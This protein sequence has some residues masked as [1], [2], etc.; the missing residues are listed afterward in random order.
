[1]RKIL[2]LLAISLLLPVAAYADWCAHSKDLAAE[3]SLDGVDAIEVLAVSG[4]LEITGSS[5]TRRV[6][7]TGRACTGAEGRDRIDEIAIREERVGGTLRIIADVPFIE[8]EDWR[9][10][11]LDLELDLPDNLPVRVTDTSGDIEI[12][13]VYS[14]QLTDSSGDVTMRGVLASVHIERDSSGDLDIR[15]VGDVTIDVDSSGDIDVVRA[16]SVMIGKD[17][18]GAIRVRDIVGDMKVGRDSSGP[19]EAVNVSGDFIVERDTSGGIRHR[20][21]GGA[22]RIPEKD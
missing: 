15:D 9:I 17:S 22:V 16:G 4:D 21:V 19:I 3:M 7:A 2:G 10:G 14:V 13:D 1:M 20:Q 5:N 18:S 8:D 12:E 6:R 11:G